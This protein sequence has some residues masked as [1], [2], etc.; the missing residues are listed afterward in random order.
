MESIM[1]KVNFSENTTEVMSN[2]IDS[3]EIIEE[4]RATVEVLCNSVTCP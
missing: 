4:T 2:E 3:L 1:T